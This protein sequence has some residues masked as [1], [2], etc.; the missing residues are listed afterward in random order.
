MIVK[1]KIGIAGSEEIILPFRGIGM[2]TY[3]VDGLDEEGFWKVSRKV[4][5]DN[6][7][8]LIVTE[9]FYEKMKASFKPGENITLLPIPGR[10]RSTGAA[11]NELRSIVAK[12]VGIDLFKSRD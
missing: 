10:K 11:L 7:R 9:E 5:K 8:I 2:R 1:G 3:P 6:V 12:A 4:L